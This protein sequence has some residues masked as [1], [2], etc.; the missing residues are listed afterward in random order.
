[1]KVHHISCGTMCP[2][3]GKLTVN[4]EGEMV[5]HCLV[6]ETREGLVLVDTGIGLFDVAHPAQALGRG[7]AAVV[8][9][10]RDPEVTMVRQL[11]RMGF[12]PGDVKH[13][14]VTHLDLDHAGGF[15][16]LPG[17]KVHAYRPEHEA[18]MAR[19]TANERRRYRPH[20]LKDVSWVVHE[21]TGEGEDW[22]GFRAVT[23]ILGLDIALIPLIG[24]TRGHCGVAIR[25]ASG[26]LLHCGDAYF[27]G[28]QMDPER[29]RCTIGLRLFQRA[30]AL[31]NQ[32]R[33]DNVARL[34]ELA[35][36][37][38]QSVRLFSR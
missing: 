22:F 14:V 7:F 21:S 27:H 25:S 19:R 11:A 29:E 31:D 15:P 37:Q 34:R 4:R 36:A 2:V 12:K 9:P 16:D 17:F 23:P 10:S 32:A 38:S 13:I 26:W 5:C 6:I 24:H 3:L 18:A 28:D 30:M 1:M 33:L 20:Q 8:R 35:R